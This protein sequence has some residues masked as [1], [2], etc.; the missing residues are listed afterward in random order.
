[1][2]EKIITADR[3]VRLIASGS[4]IAIGGTGSGHLVP[5]TILASLERRYVETGAPQALI[6]VHTMGL[7][8]NATNAG[9][10]HFAHQGLV[11]YFFGS[12]YAANRELMTKLLA[13]E[14][15]AYVLPA[16]VIA[17]LYREIAS[18]R[19]ALIT[20][21]G[22]GTF[23]DPKH[24]GA[25]T[26]P[27]LPEYVRTVNI[28]GEDYLMYPAFNLDVGI[29][30][31]SV[32]D[33]LGNLSMMD[34]PALGDNLAI[35]QAVH[36]SGGVVIAQVAEIAAARTLPQRSVAV[37]ARLVDFIVHVPDE[38]MTYATKRSDAY[39]GRFRVPSGAMPSIEMNARKII[40][41]RA[42]LELEPG[43][44]VNL[45]FGVA[46]GVAAVLAEEKRLDLVELTV[47]QG[48]YGGFPAVGMDAGAAVNHDAILDVPAQFDF[49]DGGGLDQAYLSFA[50]VD[51]HG[52]V[53]VSRFEGHLTG[54]GGFINISSS[55]RRVVFCGTLGVGSS[56]KVS[57]KGIRILKQGAPKF[58]PR[59]EQITYDPSTA[60]NIQPP[61]Y[62]TEQAVF[63]LQGG[64]LTL[65][66]VF[67]GVSV[68]EV[69]AA[70]AFRPAVA[71]DVR[72]TP[73][74]VFDT[75]AELLGQPMST[76]SVQT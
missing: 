75:T 54:P 1:M 57:S 39:S 44:L 68:E 76:N 18:K 50:Q 16:G 6:V 70:M 9:I 2:T 31:A 22:Q 8:D 73:S 36:N 69:M 30:R 33:E 27:D 35:A 37:P 64:L 71:H 24:E 72:V 17:Q 40:A 67:P 19:P 28:Q 49:Y 3:A 10:G 32:A 62:V 25:R 38:P 45:G 58:V 41:R 63:R 55:A 61:V 56:V 52:R 7:G 4:T 46:N 5:E 23:V 53:N 51:P 14:I 20:K 60:R 21:I 48:T 29:I 26:I 13:G 47:E 11:K 12:H 15:G 42:C 65:T 43:A 34:D 74:K 66:E 59:L